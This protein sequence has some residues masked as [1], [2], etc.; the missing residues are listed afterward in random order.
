[1]R[2]L[3]GW[4]NG[5][6]RMIWGDGTTTCEV[7]SANS[8]VVA[9]N[10]SWQHLAVSYDGSTLTFYVNGAPIAG[11][12]TGSCAAVTPPNVSNFYIGRPNDFGYLYFNQMSFTNLKDA[13]GIGQKAE[14][15]LN[16]NSDTS[17]GN[18]AWSNLSNGTGSWALGKTA[19]VN[20]TN[21]WFRVWDNRDGGCFITCPEDES[22]DTNYDQ[23]DWKHDATLS[24][25][26]SDRSIV[27]EA[28][29]LRALA[30]SVCSRRQQAKHCADQRES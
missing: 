29:D 2:K 14:M 10:N 8:G 7:A 23:P 24:S 25:F 3:R 30:F 18:L 17:S 22:S 5:R 27:D 12:T 16:F 11:G 21:S 13:A 20:D 1:M 26:S 9:V 6:L 19:V 28:T 4:S 15:R